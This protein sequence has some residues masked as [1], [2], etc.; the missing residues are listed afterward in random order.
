MDK[1]TIN[2]EFIIDML[3]IFSKVSMD[4][5]MLTVLARIIEPLLRAVF[6]YDRVWSRKSRVP[7][8]CVFWLIR[9]RYGGLVNVM[10]FFMGLLMERLLQGD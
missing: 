1:P 4:C 8:A 7:I 2:W 3:R 10:E 5:Y 6:G 9:R